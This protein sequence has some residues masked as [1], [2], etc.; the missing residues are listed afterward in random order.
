MEYFFPHEQPRE[1]QIPFMDQVYDTL[2]KKSQL[3]IQAPTGIGKTAAALSPALTY[4]IKENPGATIFFLTSRNTQHLIAIDTLKE[5]KNK[6]KLDFVVVDLIG[7]KG[8]CAQSGIQLLTSGEFSE[9]CKDLREKSRCTFFNNLKFQ[10]KMSP[11]AQH[12]LTKLK[13]KS[14]LHVEEI[15]EMCIGSDLCP[16]EMACHMGKK[17]Q[18]IVADYNYMIN[19]HI[20]A[21]L[22]SKINKDLS[23]CIIIFDEGHNLPGRAREFMTSQ[24]N[25][26]LLDYAAR[27][28]TNI[29]QSEIADDLTAIKR[30]LEE[31]AKEKLS[32]STPEVLITKKEFFKKIEE[33]GNYEELTGNFTFAA[34]KI[35]EE[36]KKSFTQS[37]YRF[38][39][40]WLGPDEGF[41]RI[42]SKEFA[43]NGKVRICLSH[44]CLDPSLVM[45]DL[46]QGS[47]SLIL[48][49]GT[50]TP[51]DMYA[52]LLGLSYKT[53][54]LEF[55]NPFPSSN[56]LNIIIPETSTK[57]TARSP[58][59][60]ELIATKCANISNTV[61]G[62]IVIF[63]PSYRLR[64][65]I[66]EY[67]RDKSEKTIFLEE[68]GC[69]KEERSGLLERFKRFKDEGALL[70]GVAGGSFSEG[71]DLPG[72]LL[73]GVIVVGLPL[74]QP[75]LETKELINY[76]DKRFAKGW[77]YGY[78]FPAII[79]ILQSA[80]RCIRSK[81]DRGIV[82]FLDERYLWS[83]YRKCF[84][85]NMNLKIDKNP[86]NIVNQFFKQN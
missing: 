68:A 23:D 31:M 37:V 82:A 79:K 16:Y 62:N 32:F 6:H 77:D 36:K 59:M 21:T 38:M 19:D 10:N 80:G 57:Y 75:N 20:R 58:K 34:E 45:K 46:I 65:S 11:E 18:V 7:K 12:V 3:L 44:K 17:A 26:M 56:R 35:L 9:Y 41:V 8:M 78:V 71:I 5:I 67:L 66:Y 63:F 85:K 74:A 29:G 69:S 70:L 60:Y 50:L 86:E 81:E 73:Q 54:T 15:T 42:L 2:K 49:S 39:T 27:E 52:D 25:T 51:L 76:Y 64:D 53:K 13:E 22:L 43:K 61:P 14:P 28:T 30:L 40:N 72:D 48:M 4:V 33:I 84:P 47:H 55:D 1:V 83:S 24:T